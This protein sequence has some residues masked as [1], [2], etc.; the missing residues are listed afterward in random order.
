[1]CSVMFL[2][3]KNKD[4]S[5]WLDNNILSSKR[6]TSPRKLVSMWEYLTPIFNQPPEEFSPIYTTIRDICNSTSTSLFITQNV[7]SFVEVLPESTTTV[8]LNGIFKFTYCLKCDNKALFKPNMFR[9]DSDGCWL[10]P[11][12][13]LKG[14][15]IKRKALK[16]VYECIHKHSPDICY[17]VGV[18]LD[19]DYYMHKII[20]KIEQ[21][22]TTIIHVLE[23]T[24]STLYRYTVSYDRHTSNF[25]YKIRDIPHE[26]M[27]E[28]EFTQ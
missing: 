14:E 1:M 12:I 26:V 22:G 19:T 10:R 4:E 8:E 13:R 20:K 27:T 18:P 25:M 23:D 28:K 9:C 15:R 17:I 5:S 7:N 24:P 11:C 16:Q 6:L 21:N 2:I 3:G